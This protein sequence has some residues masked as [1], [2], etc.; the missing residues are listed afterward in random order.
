[1]ELNYCR[2]CGA[3][4]SKVPEG[5]YRCSN[6][7]SIFASAAP[8]VGVFFIT[9]DDQVILSRRGVEPDKGMLDSFGGFVEA[10]ETTETAIARELLEETGLAPD[11][12]EPLEFLC[13][14]SAGYLY[15]GENRP[16]LSTF[17]CSAMKPHAKPVA[18]DDVAEIVTLPLSEIKLEEFG[19]DDVKTAFELLLSKRQ[20]AER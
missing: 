3:T 11:D 6:G 20:D 15:E 9:K 18:H 12:Y 8:T 5:Y 2:R 14:A 19:G 1:M 16:V 4:L 10:D 7:H 17:F 13:T